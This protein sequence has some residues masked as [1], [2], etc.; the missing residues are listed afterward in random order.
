MNISKHKEILALREELDLL[1]KEYKNKQSAV[2]DFHTNNL[3]TAAVKKFIEYVKGEGFEINGDENDV[4]IAN[5]DGIIIR[6]VRKPRIFTV[7]M[8]NNER[9]SVSVETTLEF[10]INR[11]Q[12][13]IS[14]DR[15]IEQLKQSIAKVKD[16]FLLIDTQQFRYTLSTEEYRF[17]NMKAFKRSFFTFDDILKEMF[18]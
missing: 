3:L 1:E 2:V 7:N 5:L 6:L 9:Y 11:V 16:Q 4:L 18:S 14:Q 12:P 15:E 10:S 13:G 8:P 17:G